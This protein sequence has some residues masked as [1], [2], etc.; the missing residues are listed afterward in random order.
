MPRL[1]SL[2]KNR[3]LTALQT[4]AWS[5]RVWQG[6]KGHIIRPFHFACDHLGK[7]YRAPVTWEALSQG[8]GEVLTKNTWC[9]GSFYKN[10]FISA[11]K[12]VY[13]Y[14]GKLAMYIY[15]IKRRHITAGDWFEP[16]A[17]HRQLPLTSG[18]LKG[19]RVWTSSEECTDSH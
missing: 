19:D 12:E 2:S 8:A 10:K 17:T 5:L 1:L 3:G 6:L 7:L 11:L 14:L 15:R 9:L 18:M 13:M 16:S 4:P